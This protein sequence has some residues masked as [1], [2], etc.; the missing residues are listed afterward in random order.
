MSILN[1]GKNIGNV[2]KDMYAPSK[3]AYTKSKQQTEKSSIKQKIC[4]KIF[5]A[6]V[7]S[8]QRF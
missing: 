4:P 5:G 6:I 7:Q 1:Q 8:L 3:A 2:S